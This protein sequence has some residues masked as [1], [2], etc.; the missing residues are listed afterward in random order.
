MIVSLIES[1]EGCYPTGEKF[2]LH[3][4]DD[5]YYMRIKLANIDLIIQTPEGR[6]KFFTDVSYMRLYT[7]EWKIS[8][9]AD[10]TNGEVSIADKYCEHNLKWRVE[11]RVYEEFTFQR[12]D[13]RGTQFIHAMR[14]QAPLLN[15]KVHTQEGP[16]TLGLELGQNNITMYRP[17][18]QT[19]PTT[20]SVQ[21]LLC[22]KERK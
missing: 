7:N 9:Y 20:P 2:S 10:E 19:L 18:I 21:G 1:P 12:E 14:D 17:D 8:W 15:T 22:K 6:H 3:I 4:Y 5:S 11:D 13:A 16:Q